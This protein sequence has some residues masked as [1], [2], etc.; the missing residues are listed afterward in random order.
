MTELVVVGAG[1]A[2]ANAVRTLR[3]EGF[4]GRVVLL[5]DEHERP[6]DRPPLSKD[7][8]LG[9]RERAAV[10]LHDEH[11]Y[12]ANSV[13]LRLG[14]PVTGL[15]RAA[16]EV[17]IAG[18]ER[19]RYTKLLL[20]TGS[21]PRRLRVPGADLAGVHHL[22]RIGEA[23]RLRE[24]LHAGGRVVVAGAGWIGLEI[25]AAARSRGCPVT[26]VEPAPTPLHAAL[27]PRIGGFFADLHRGNGV[28]FRFGTQVA[29]LRGSDRVT[30]VITSDGQEIPADLVVAG[31]GAHPNISLAE[32]AGLATEAGGIRVDASLRT[33]DPDIYAAGD[34][35]A[36]PSARYGGRL[37]VEHWANAVESGKAA[38]RAML[39]HEVVYDELPYFFT[40]QYD[41]GMEFTGHPGGHD[42][43][44]TRGDIDGRAFHAFWLADGEVVAGMHV[45][46]WE[47]GLG[48]VRDLIQTRRQVDVRRLSDAAV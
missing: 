21:R 22:R 27:G 14:S 17:E 34:V 10:Y 2:A 46:C 25:A 6:Y 4:G 39:G 40:D 20:A 44:V 12:E 32:Q 18:G 41:V 43:V 47:E 13:E 3:E 37:R 36:I 26:V 35:A 9:T 24:A 31:I 19:I 33:D 5:G 30:A 8:L 45:N 48:G 28:D 29:E 16:R 15:D 7:Y 1:L 42:Q 23:D 38:A 11:W